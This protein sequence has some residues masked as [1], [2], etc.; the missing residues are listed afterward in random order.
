MSEAKSKNAA[1]IVGLDIIRFAAAFMVMWFHLAYST[2]AARSTPY[3]FSGGVFDAPH[4]A[5]FS[6]W[7]WVGVQI[8]FVLSGF[9][10]AF[11][12]QG[13]SP[14]SF[15]RSRFLRLY[16]GAWVSCAAIALICIALHLTAT[17]PFA[18]KDLVVLTLKSAALWP[19]APWLDS[20]F[21]TLG[22]EMS[23]Y[24]VIFAVLLV[25]RFHQIGNVLA[26]I[27][28][29][30]CAAIFAAELALPIAIRERWAELTLL[31][32]GI[33]F[34]LGGFLWIATT[35]A[36]RSVEYVLI[37]TFTVAAMFEISAWADHLQVPAL[38]PCMI[39]LGA[40]L[41]VHLAAQHNTLLI[42][43]L[44]NRAPNFVR[45][46]GLATYPLYLLHT[47]VGASTMSWLIRSGV[48]QHVA[49]AIGMA[50]AV[51]ASLLVALHAEPA[52]RALTSKVMTGL[53]LSSPPKP[54]HPLEQ[55]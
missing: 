27:G 11:S 40:T 29:L 48:N 24:A 15:A 21:W 35:R 32:H 36:L 53:S 18:A 6:N 47:A 30:S 20:V 12:A 25:G 31:P 34:A 42:A 16:P 28:V 14:A 23:F 39:W 43:L 33:Y 38:I 52:V 2:W 4:L 5:S 3:R 46:L 1:T 49:L 8:F 44:P 45:N 19:V 9:V 51:G 17:S 50:A 10:I 22:V 54:Q 26:V 55:N 41:A 13:K 37:A 7:G